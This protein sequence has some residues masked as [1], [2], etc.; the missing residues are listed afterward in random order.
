MACSCLALWHIAL[1]LCKYNIRAESHGGWTGPV[2]LVRIFGNPL[3]EFE[4]FTPHSLGSV[5]VSKGKFFHTGLWRGWPVWLLR[6]V[7]KQEKLQVTTLMVSR[8]RVTPLESPCRILNLD[9][10]SWSTLLQTKRPICGR[11]TMESSY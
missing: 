9:T 4:Y 7:N 3:N 8:W 6:P 11:A 1:F 5:L 10:L 2:F